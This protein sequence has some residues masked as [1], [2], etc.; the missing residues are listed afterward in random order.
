VVPV[1]EHRIV[2][3]SSMSVGNARLALAGAAFHHQQ[4]CTGR[5]APMRPFLIPALD[6]G[7]SRAWLHRGIEYFFNVWNRTLACC[8]AGIAAIRPRKERLQRS[9]P[10]WGRFFD[11][12]P[13]TA[14]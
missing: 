1:L 5:V 11:T 13:A 14:N 3:E 7:N 9:V 6:A 4:I 10:H 8:C 12:P 2:T